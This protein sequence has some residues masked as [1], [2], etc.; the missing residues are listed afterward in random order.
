MGIRTMFSSVVAAGLTL[1]LVPLGCGGAQEQ[2]TSVYRPVGIGATLP[3]AARRVQVEA[4]EGIRQQVK[5]CMDLRAGQWPERSYAVQ[6]DAK[7]DDRGEM[8]EVKIRGT[9][10]DDDEVVECLRQ[11]IAAMTIPEDALRMRLSR[12]VSG[13]ERMTR[14]RRGPIGDSDSQ[15]PFVLLGPMIVEAVGVQVIVEVGVGIIAAVATLVMP[16]KLPPKDECTDKYSD[17]MD[18]PLGKSSSER[19]WRVVVRN[20][21]ERAARRTDIGRRP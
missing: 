2:S 11:A 16:K 4:S 12:P 9:T 20:R 7:A 3:M 13:G 15:N 6:M 14:E 18:S 1:A 5:A 10:M 21:A 19:I 8:Q 17:C